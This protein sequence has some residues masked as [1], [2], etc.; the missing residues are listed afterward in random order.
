MK[1]GVVDLWVVEGGK[2]NSGQIYYV[3]G[4]FMD[5]PATPTTTSFRYRPNTY[6]SIEYEDRLLIVVRTAFILDE[7]CRPVDGVHVGGRVPL[8]PDS[9]ELED[10]DEV[11]IT[12]C[13]YPPPGYGPWTSGSGT[14]G[15][16]FESWIYVRSKPEH[17][18]AAK[19]KSGKKAE[20]NQ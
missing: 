15:S 18:S 11:A 13:V 12:E 4:E 10:A 9:E 19:Q 2:G 5:L 6:E 1:K 20:E 8:L 17:Q 14:P 16:T 3:D 7:C